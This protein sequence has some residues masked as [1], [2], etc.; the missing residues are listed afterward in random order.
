M[1]LIKNIAQLLTL[2]PHRKGELGEIDDAALVIDDAKIVWCGKEND[3]PPFHLT[4]IIDAKKSLVLPGLIDCHSHLLFAG[5]RADEFLRR[6]NKESYEHIMA[7]GGG[8]MST[9]KATRAAS[10]EELLSLCLMRA[11]KILAS[12]T[13]T[14][15]A[16]SGYGLSAQE[17]IRHLSILKKVNESHLLDIHPTFLGAH[18]VPDEYKKNPHQYVKLVLEMLEQVVFERLAVD[19]DVFSESTAFS[20]KD[21]FTILHRAYELGMGL[22]AHVQQLGFSDGVKLLLR[23]PIKSISHADFLSEEDIG[24]IKA[25]GVVV[26]ALPFVS[27]F[28]PS[29]HK[30]PVSKLLLKEIPVALATDF[31]PGSAMCHDLLLAARLGV[32]LMGFSIKDA[33]LGITRHA[34]MSLGRDDIGVLKLGAKADVLI[35]NVKS[36]AELFYDWSN[37]PLI[38]VIK[39]GQLVKRRD[40]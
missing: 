40:F 25:S 35:T 8:I 28:A 1:L 34:A 5:S 22:R 2:D 23:L 38:K 27:L 11:D 20:L 9:V 37:H 15:E 13:T 12:G 3:L 4:N 39:N 32:T 7:L 21:S 26:E 6:M 16:K 10:E 24:I 31:N 30:T 36:T 17:E 18:V 33:L 14:L 29:S 19:C